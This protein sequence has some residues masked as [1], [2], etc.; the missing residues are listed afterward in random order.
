MNSN[1]AIDQGF[2]P[3]PSTFPAI[4]FTCSEYPGGEGDIM[5]QYEIQTRIGDE[6][7]NEVGADNVFT[8]EAEAWAAIA[9]LKTLGDDWR[10]AEYRVEAEPI[11]RLFSN[12]RI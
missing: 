5:E 4:K 6:W 2:I 10:D 3:Y 1:D 8:S 11:N 12:I 7:S 9:E